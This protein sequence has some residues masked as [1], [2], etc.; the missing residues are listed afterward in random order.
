MIKV[1]L[2]ETRDAADFFRKK[3]QEL[4]QISRRL[5]SE[6]QGLYA[7]W[8]GMSE[9]TFMQDYQQAE[10]ILMQTGTVLQEIAKALD[11]IATNFDT[12]DRAR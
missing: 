3:Q 4:E 1:N 5:N 2:R 12:A 10:Q 9:Q 6:L 7:Q 11:T 8:E